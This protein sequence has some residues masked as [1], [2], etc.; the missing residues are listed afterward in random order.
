[1]TDIYYPDNIS[2]MVRIRD[3][4]VELQY[5]HVYLRTSPYFKN[6]IA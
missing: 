1:M 2:V 6:N 3:A 5:V 4:I